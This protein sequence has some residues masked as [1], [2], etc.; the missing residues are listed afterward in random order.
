[1]AKKYVPTE[2]HRELVKAMTAI[3][4]PQDDIALCVGLTGKTLRK[5][6]AEEIKLGMIRANAAVGGALFNLAT[7]P[8]TGQATAAIFWAKTRMGW[9]EPAQGIE[10]TG[11]DGKPIEVRKIER[12]IISPGATNS[13]AKGKG[14]R[15][16]ED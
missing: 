11:K 10:L 4:T 2:A 15:S 16:P 5:H 8:G 7:K 13:S 12:V 3:G 6:Y 1:V 14:E 9:K